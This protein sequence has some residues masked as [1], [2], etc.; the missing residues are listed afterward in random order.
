MRP[1]R[2]PH[3]PASTR[4]ALIPLVLTAGL[5]GMAGASSA[6]ASL[7]LGHQ[8]AESANYSAGHRT[9]A[10]PASGGRAA[11]AAPIPFTITSPDFHD[12]GRLPNWTEFGGPYA[13]E[14]GCAGK[15]ESPALNWSDPPAG[16]ES[17]ALFVHDLDAP[18]SWGFN[19]WVA[20]NIP[21]SV[22]SLAKN[23]DTAYTSGTNDW[24]ANGVPQVGYGGP[25]PPANGETHHYAFTL[26]AL[27]TPD[28]TTAGLTYAGLM[29]AM[30]PDVLGATTIIGTYS[31]S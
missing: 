6:S 23:D 11:A 30:A 27:S 24:Q 19:H 10:N 12:G 5:V 22:D 21:A 1:F 31:L 13:G 8:P 20:Y 18:Q 26:Y 3:A 7:G 28:I 2:L 4:R 9:L 17:Y 16:T 25:C 14:V 15:N 29:N